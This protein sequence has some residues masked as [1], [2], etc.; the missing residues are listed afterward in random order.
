MTRG[1]GY[2]APTAIDVVVADPGSGSTV[3]FTPSVDLPDG[4]YVWHVRS[5]AGSVNGCY[6]DERSLTVD[7]NVVPSA[8]TLLLPTD[9]AFT[10]DITPLFDWQDVTDG[11]GINRYNIQISTS[12][13]LGGSGGFATTVIDTNIQAPAVSQFTP[14]TDLAVG[15]YY[16]HVR[17]RDGGNNVGPFSS[18]F[19][20]TI[21]TILPTAPSITSPTA[22]T[23]NTPISSISG[24]SGETDLTIEVFNGATSLDDNLRCWRR[25]DS[26]IRNS[27]ERCTYSLTV[28]G[29]RCRN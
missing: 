8:P 10:N 23:Q 14:A 17:A 29:Y 25:L 15:T 22:G 12:P 9:D 21:D 27:T 16:W 7:D 6:S 28:N 26:N 1:F 24:T 2:D 18:I 19:S 13:T 4:N 3:S 5:I 11:S 20:F